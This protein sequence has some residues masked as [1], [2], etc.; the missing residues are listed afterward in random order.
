MPEMVIS[1]SV[2]ERFFSGMEITFTD[3]HLGH[4]IRFCEAADASRGNPQLLHLI[5]LFD[6][7]CFLFVL[8]VSQN[9]LVSFV[10]GVEQTTLYLS[11]RFFGADGA[12]QQIDVVFNLSF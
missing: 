8:S 9:N 11:S 10:D 5:V 4:L 7:C 12:L 3:P 2:V 6:I 1:L